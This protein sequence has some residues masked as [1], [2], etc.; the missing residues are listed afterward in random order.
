MPPSSY[1]TFSVIIYIILIFIFWKRLAQQYWRSRVYFITTK[2]RSARLM[3]ITIFFLPYY[4]RSRA[5]SHTS[6][7]CIYKSN[8][9][10]VG[11]QFK[12]KYYIT[13]RSKRLPRSR[14]RHYYTYYCLSLL[15]HVSAAIY[16]TKRK[17]T[18]ILARTVYYYYYC[19]LYVVYYY[20]IAIVRP[21]YN[22]QCTGLALKLWC[23][24]STG[25]L[26]H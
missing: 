16:Y 22:A 17:P 24:V 25:W 1:Y 9:V 10:G 21:F 18:G 20:Y 6:K 8:R 26:Y 5:I 4:F 12:K 14:Y 11:P 19:N 15:S 7:K 13:F 23:S 2:H 3:N